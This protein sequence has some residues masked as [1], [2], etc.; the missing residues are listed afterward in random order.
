MVALE[1]HHRKEHVM[2]A[3]LQPALRFLIY[4]RVGIPAIRRKSRQVIIFSYG[5]AADL[6]PRLDGLDGT[7]HFPDAVRD[8]LTSPFGFGP[9]LAVFPESGVVV[10]LTG[11]FRIA[12]I[13]EMDAV[14]IIVGGQFTADG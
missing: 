2:Y 10:E 4:G 12:D 9:S 1:V 14:Q 3:F 7:V 13:V 6:D 8:I 11:V 5:R